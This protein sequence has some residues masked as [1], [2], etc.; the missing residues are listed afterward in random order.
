[1]LRSLIRQARQQGALTTSQRVRSLKR[2]HSMR[3]LFST[4]C[5]STPSA[6]RLWRCNESIQCSWH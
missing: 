6:A 4:R 3:E 2:L 5:S 1:M